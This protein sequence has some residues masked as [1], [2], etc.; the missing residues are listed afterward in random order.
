M[1]NQLILSH[2]FYLGTLNRS[3]YTYHL[4]IL[5]HIEF[6]V[7]HVEA[8]NI[9]YIIIVTKLPMLSTLFKP[10]PTLSL[11]RI[12]TSS[13]DSVTLRCRYASSIAS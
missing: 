8:Q 13:T 6:N 4:P 5:S 7:Q 10:I 2:F 1:L 3:Q 11:S 9:H 12:I